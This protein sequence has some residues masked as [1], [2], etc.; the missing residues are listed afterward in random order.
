LGVIS[1]SQGLST[2]APLKLI[3]PLVANERGDSMSNA[4][5]TADFFIMAISGG[6]YL[7]NGNPY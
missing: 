5:K 6:G 7:N 3:C 1:V 4:S 2:I